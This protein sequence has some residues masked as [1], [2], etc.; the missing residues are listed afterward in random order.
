MYKHLRANSTFR[1]FFC[2]LVLFRGPFSVIFCKEGI[3]QQVFQIVGNYSLP[4]NSF[5]D[6]L[7][8]FA[9][10]YE[11]LFLILKS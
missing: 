2:Q 5:I 4:I 7:E 3:R 10:L 1:K 6:L 9:I 11:I 8:I